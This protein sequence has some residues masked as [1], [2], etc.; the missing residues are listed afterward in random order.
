MKTIANKLL[1]LFSKFSV[2]FSKLQGKQCAVKKPVK[3]FDFPGSLNTLGNRVEFD[4]FERYLQKNALSKLQS[5]AP[6]FLKNKLISD[7]HPIA[8]KNILVGRSKTWASVKK[9]VE[10]FQN[11][12]F[13]QS[14]PKDR[15]A[16]SVFFMQDR[17]LDRTGTLDPTRATYKCAHGEGSGKNLPCHR[18]VEPKRY[19]FDGEV[20]QKSIALGEILT[21]GG[22]LTEKEVE[23]GLVWQVGSG[24][25]TKKSVRADVAMQK[26]E[27][28]RKGV[29]KDL[30]IFGLLRHEY[31][32]VCGVSLQKKWRQS[33]NS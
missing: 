14:F 26:I 25:I 5:R 27:P 30:E 11:I 1:S 22:I 33:W 31:P 28:S 10:F 8:Q 29:E 18:P 3:W 20:R 15:S 21:V 13:N 7:L 17:C 9:Y 24:K 12:F 23:K 2:A 6:I 19:F 4:G 32:K 16:E